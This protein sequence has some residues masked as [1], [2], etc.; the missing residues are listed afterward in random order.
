[1]QDLHDEVGPDRFKWPLG[2]FIL[3]QNKLL[4]VHYVYDVLF[5]HNMPDLFLASLS[6]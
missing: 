6:D 5:M 3:N 1:M 2:Y 4:N